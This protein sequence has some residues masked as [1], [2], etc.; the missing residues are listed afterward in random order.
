VRASLPAPDPAAARISELV[1]AAERRLV[2]HV[3]SGREPAEILSTAA[4]AAL[5]AVLVGAGWHDDEIAVQLRMTPYTTARIRNR[6]G[7]RPNA[8]HWR[9]A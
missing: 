4:R 1:A 6:I 3:L 5:I 2:F 9:T 8:L 7:L